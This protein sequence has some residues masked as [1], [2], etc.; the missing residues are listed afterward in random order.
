MVGLFCEAERSSKERFEGALDF[1]VDPGETFT[2]A[3]ACDDVQ[4]IILEDAD[5]RVVAGVSPETDSNLPRDGDEFRCGDTI[6]FTFDHG[7]L[8]VDFGVTI[9]IADSSGGF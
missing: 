6:I 9:S 2:F 1:I 3:L 4:A 5:L 8:L 7:L